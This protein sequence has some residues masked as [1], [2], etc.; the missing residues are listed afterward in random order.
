MQP[1]PEVIDRYAD[2]QVQ[3]QGLLANVG[4]YHG[5]IATLS[6]DGEL[7]RITFAW[8]AYNVGSL[9]GPEDWRASSRL[10]ITLSLASCQGSVSPDLFYLISPATNE[11]FIFCSTDDGDDLMRPDEVKG[12]DP[13]HI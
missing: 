1:T 10:D 7:L 12:L 9:E 5:Q 3:I 2:G 6:L 4:V 8:M 11:T 13:S